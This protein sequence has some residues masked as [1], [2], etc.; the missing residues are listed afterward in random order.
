MEKDNDMHD[1]YRNARCLGQE[2]FTMVEL[3]IAMGIIAIMAAIAVPSIISWL[4][5]YRLKAAA[6]EMISNFQKAKLEAVKR[7]TDVVITFTKANA[8]QAGS[9]QIFVDD[10]P[11]NGAFDAGERVLVDHKP[12]PKDVS[13]YNTTFPGNLTGFNSR[14]LPTSGVATY[15]ALMRNNNS[16]YYRIALSPAGSIRLQM[17]NDGINWN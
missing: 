9:Y 2:G 17:S 3:M 13:L 4:P 11:G 10:N 15:F 8:T 12:M 16:R 6:S 14:G 1:L 7:N 5:N